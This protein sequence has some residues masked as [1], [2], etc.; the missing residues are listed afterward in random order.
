MGEEKFRHSGASRNPDYQIKGRFVDPGLR[1]DDA[2]PAYI[3]R[4]LAIVS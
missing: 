2:V 3:P 4:S 1:R